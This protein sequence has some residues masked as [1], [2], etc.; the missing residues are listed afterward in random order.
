MAEY[1]AFELP[2]PPSTNAIWRTAGGRVHRSAS[3]QEWQIAA[4]YQLSQ[5][6][7][8]QKVPGPIGIE[9]RFVKPSKRRMD[10]DNRIKPVL[11]LLVA[12]QVIDDDCLV[13]NISAQWAQDGA[14]VQ[15]LV[16]AT[17]EVA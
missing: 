5:Q 15:V 12:H 10:L 13:Q 7:R 2:F 9:L 14:P 16:T 11:D 8:S 17:R 3:Y 4:G 1:L 6:I